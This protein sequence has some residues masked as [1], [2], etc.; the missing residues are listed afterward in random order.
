M[1][2]IDT[3]IERGVAI[4]RG[5][6]VLAFATETVYGLG[7]DARSAAAVQTIYTLKQRP[8]TH[9]LIVH[10]ADF[11]ALHE[12]AWSP[13]AAAQRLIEK[14]TPGALTL[15]LPR[16]PQVLPAVCGGGDY[17]A[18]RAPSHPLAQQLLKTFGGGVA[19]PSANRFGRISPTCAAHVAD[20][21]KDEKDLYILDGGACGIGLESTIVGFD[22]SKNDSPFIAR[23]GDIS[24]AAIE[25]VTNQPLIDAPPQLSAPG[26]LPRHY[27]PA[28]PLTIVT[29][30]EAAAAH[31][32][33][34][35][36]ATTKPAAVADSLYR[37]AAANA[38]QYAQNLYRFLR[39]LDQATPHEIWVE[40]PPTTEEWQAI[41][42]RLT[43][44]A[45]P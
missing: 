30:K 31:S 18:L 29:P 40:Q 7:G 25:R 8:H 34:G 9:P 3:D 43:R 37:P 2:T 36:I 5:G 42:D 20:E 13:P 35:I 27:A 21:F 12:W 44:A 15:L 23:A 38:Q 19:A 14:F 33:T 11:S 4:L 26:N 39:E 6:G 16:A 45:A 1:P 17:I 24:A 41:N 10:I 28:T 22:N 32:N